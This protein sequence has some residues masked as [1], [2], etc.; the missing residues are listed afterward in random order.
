MHTDDY[1]GI[2][3]QVWLKLNETRQDLLAYLLNEESRLEKERLA[4]PSSH[5]CFKKQTSVTARL[6]EMTL[7][8]KTL[9]S[10]TDKQSKEQTITAFQIEVSHLVMNRAECLRLNA[11]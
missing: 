7:A 9:C 2:E 4:R 8:V 11:N 6:N 3:Q 1:Y 5:P 10:N